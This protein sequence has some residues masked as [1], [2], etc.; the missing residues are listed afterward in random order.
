MGGLDLGFSD[1]ERRVAE[2]VHSIAFTEITR[3]P[4]TSEIDPECGKEVDVVSSER[5]ELS[6]KNLSRIFELLEK[7]RD[8]REE[9]LENFPDWC[10]LRKDAIQKLTEIEQTIQKEKFWCNVGKI[11]GHVIGGAGAVALASAFFFPPAAP[12][13]LL[14]ASL[15]GIAPF[16]PSFLLPAAPA[17]LLPTCLSGIAPF[18]PS[19]LL[20]AAPA[21]VSPLVVNGGIAAGIGGVSSLGTKAAELILLRQRMEAAKKVLQGDK[22][23]FAYMENWFKHTKEL[24][25]A[26]EDVIGF[27]VIKQ[28][29]EDMDALFVGIKRLNDL[30]NKSPLWLNAAVKLCVRQMLT[31]KLFD[32]YL[33]H[34]LSAVIVTFMFV[35]G[36][37]SRRNRF[38]FKCIVKTKELMSRFYI[39]IDA[40]VELARVF[41]AVSVGASSAIEY[42]PVEA[43]KEVSL[44]VFAGLG[45]AISAANIVLTSIDI[46]NGSTCKQREEIK[47]AAEK[48]QEELD[49]L[50]EVRSAVDTTEALSDQRNTR[51]RR[52]IT[53]N[54]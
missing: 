13:A 34:D 10:V 25:D 30:K 37:L 42:I 45:I 23:A 35:V 53:Q 41:A 38:I 40:V 6:K 39:D 14:P 43:A 22:R 50:E 51:F 54:A 7:A 31:G 12:A 33:G 11:A 17:A 3:H 8:A 47:K 48:L 26:I 44:G 28:L 20:P 4:N 36:F 19:F 1:E 16:V 21:I 24:I 29:Y 9:F 52:D 15:S 32:K 27:D 2:T 49:L 18:V 5:I 46:K